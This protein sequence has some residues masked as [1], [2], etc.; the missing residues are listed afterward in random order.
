[1]RVLN[2]MVVSAVLVST[3]VLIALCI[4]N[5]DYQIGKP[6]FPT[7]ESSTGEFVRLEPETA[8]NR[9]IQ[10]ET[11]HFEC[12]MGFPKTDQETTAESTEES[13]SE[14]TVPESTEED[15]KPFQYYT[16]GGVEL[17]HGLQEHLWNELNSNG[18]GWYFRYA[19]CVIRQESICDPWCEASNGQ[20][21]GILQ[22]RM[23]Y[24]DWERGDIFD[25]YLQITVYVEN[26]A[27]R[28]A[29]G[30]DLYTVISDHYTGEVGYDEQ[31][32]EDV[33][34]WYSEIRGE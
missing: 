18:I 27:R 23:K 5:P 11:A 4:I 16:V 14:C 30:K 31:Y 12:V 6:V 17:D 22:F 10:C 32:V 20:D 15:E 19:L 21:K 7:E 9:Q 1:M 28:L 33:L 26:T 3:F 2:A 8:K 13:A 24:W 34:Q 29:D 25:P